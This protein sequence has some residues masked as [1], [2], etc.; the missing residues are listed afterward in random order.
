MSE[1]SDT[2]QRMFRKLP[3]GV[4]DG[5]PVCRL[6]GYVW[7]GRPSAA[8]EYMLPHLKEQHGID[9]WADN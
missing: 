8:E 5:K 1:L 2:Y 4:V 3:V 6:C 7:D 9:A